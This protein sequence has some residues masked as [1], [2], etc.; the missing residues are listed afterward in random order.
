M[1]S[2]A[3]IVWAYPLIMIAGQ[4]LPWEYS[5]AA[6]IM[7]T[8]LGLIEPLRVLLLFGFTMLGHLTWFAIFQC[9]AENIAHKPWLRILGRF[10]LMGYIILF[11]AWEYF[12]PCGHKYLRFG[13]MRERL[14]F[15][16]IW[17]G[18]NE[19]IWRF[20]LVFSA[21][22]CTAIVFFCLRNNNFS[23]LVYG[24]LFAVINSMLEE[25]LWR[26][27]V[28]GRTVDFLGEK[29][30]LVITAITFGFYH[31][32]LGFSVWTCLLFAIGGFYM[33]GCAIQ[34]KG[35]G[36]SMIMHILVNLVFV[37]CGIIF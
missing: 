18:F 32:S 29:Q 9:L 7:F 27:F 17:R 6:G 23:I 20:V 34:S 2:F 37:S 3:K 12:Q 35:L 13:N 24:L 19:N 1:K 31:L 11:A 30:A 36:A 33:G 10:G 15:P 26:G 21:L 28:T 25:I 4:L 5:L 14:K 16:L 8:I 22:C